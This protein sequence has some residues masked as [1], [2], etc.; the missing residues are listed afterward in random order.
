MLQNPGI[1]FRDPQLQQCSILKD[2]QRQPRPWAGAFAVVYKGMDAA[3]SNPFAV[4]IFTTESPER[5]ERYEL[6]S[7]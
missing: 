1:A 6:T 5:R 7:A 2:A 3:G 4:R